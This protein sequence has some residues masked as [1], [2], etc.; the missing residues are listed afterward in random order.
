M[1]NMSE[2][3]SY[4]RA[5][6]DDIQ[7]GRAVVGYYV[8]Q[9]MKMLL[10]DLE[11]PELQIDFADSEKRI[12]FIE[13]E[14][15]H[16][17]APFAGK[18]FILMPWQKAIIE[19][20]FAIKVYN[21][22]LGRY[23]RKYQ[24]VL[25]VV[26]RKNGKA[27]AIDT[28]IPTPY[29]WRTM[30]DLKIGDEVFA[31]DGT[32]SKVIA[33][34]PV[35]FGHQCYKVRFEDGAEIIADTDHLWSVTTKKRR[36]P[37]VVTTADMQK[38]FVHKHADGK[39]VEYKYRVPMNEPVK[40]PH[41]LLPISPYVLGVWLGDGESSCGRISCGVADFEEMSTLITS[42]G[43]NIS[44][45]RND[46][47]CLRLYISMLSSKLCKLNLLNNKHI[48]QIYLHSSI[49]QRWELLQGLMDADGFCSKA[50]E[51]EFTQKSKA[52]ADG[53][54]KLLSSLGIKNTVTTK[55]PTI[56][57][58]KCAMVYRVTFFTDQL[59]PCFK[60]KRKLVR[61]KPALNKRMQYKSI[62]DISPVESVPV[63]CIG[64]DH[65]S[66]LYLA[67][68]HFT[69]T[70]N[71]PLASAI[72]LAEWCCG[73]M[74]TKI[75]YGSN[76]YDQ[77]DLLFM[78][79]DAMR[80][81]SP[82]LAR[83]TRRNQKGIF[84]GSLK[85]KRHV[86]KFT[87]QNKGSIRKMSA[88]TS[89]KEGRNIKIGVVDE[90][91]ELKD[92]AF[93]M[94]IKQALSTQ[95]EPLYLEITT[96]GFTEDGYLDSRL[97]TAAAVLDGEIEKPNLLIF[98]YAQDSEEEIW[99]DENSWY[100]SNPGL[101]VIKKW[102][103]LRGMVEDAKLSA[104]TRAFV[105]AKDFNV[106]QNNSSAWLPESVIVNTA[107]F[108]L[109]M[110]RG[111]F[112]VGGIDLSETT[113]LTAATAL[114]VNP[115]TKQKFALS[116]YFIPEIK[117]DARYDGGALNPE[118]KDYRE[119][120]RQGFVTICPGNE[121]DPDAVVEWYV[122]LMRQFDVKPLKFGFDNWHAASLKKG[123]ASMFGEDTLVRVGMNFF[124]LNNPMS[125]LESDLTIKRINF[126]NNPVTFWCLKN[127]ALKINNLGMKMP[128]KVH[129][130]KNRI[131]GAVALIIAYA[132]AATCKSEYDLLQKNICPRTEGG[133]KICL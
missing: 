96:E 103:F 117:L 38:N 4:I 2:G 26:A 10:A 20:I 80:E 9:Q 54:I 36:E 14:C 125:V 106:K 45:V 40:Y 65:P 66:Q 43:Y 112:Y 63:K 133:E 73:E 95:D 98:W 29:G 53:I 77:A 127:T 22:E 58:R 99:R 113:D 16:S 86:G 46:K 119:W 30:S 47:T 50:G 18:P 90:V 114:F 1:T 25:L 83:C 79:T 93:V 33:T 109:E 7:S 124:A 69:A 105:L 70:H 104:A 12:R 52:I 110:L 32:P 27:L 57:G 75:L 6:W 111:Q 81:A 72:T 49:R 42:D 11:N 48:P 5:Y 76:D 21:A 131:D 121:V 108:D 35:Q 62:V 74:G 61:L 67:G 15:R 123:L 78:A 126:G 51:C 89:A 92:D 37:F 97:K 88:H 34:S 132:A 118:K 122:E 13:R 8:R 115:W 100:K 116:K 91:H 3:E 56:N 41:K 31:A 59:S 68:E 85:Q 19:A 84:F 60:L 94:P 87:S 120:A 55:I 82:K 128:V 44:S 101:G 129:Q 107:T 130:S 71:T 28:K 17:E 24:E 23:V 102:S 64:I 39:G